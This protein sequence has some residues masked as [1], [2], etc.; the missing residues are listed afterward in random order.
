MKNFLFIS[1]KFIKEVG[2]LDE[3]YFIYFEEID[4]SYRGKKFG[5]TPDICVDSIVYHK[6]SATIDKENKKI[7]AFSDFYAMR[8]R[9]LFAKKR[10]K[11]KLGFVYLSLLF[12]FINRIRRGEIEKAKNVLRILFQGEKCS[13]KGSGR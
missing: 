1:K 4:I 7:S 2:L 11:S 3:D 10:N 13:F 8:N 12:A 5:Y 6:E 9:L